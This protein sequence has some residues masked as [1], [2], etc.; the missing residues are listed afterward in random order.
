LKL[1]VFNWQDRLNPQAGGAEVHLHEIFSRLVDAGHEVTLVV[2]G[3]SGAP[4]E[5]VVDGMDVHRVGSRHSFPLLAP[6]YYRRVLAR[7]GYDLLIEDLNKVPLWSPVWSK[8]PVVLVVHHLFGGTAFS[9]AALPVA[10]VTWLSERPLPRVYRGCPVQVV[11]ESTAADLVE[12]GFA[13]ELIRVVHNGVDLDYYRPDPAVPRTPDPS[14]VFVGRLQKYKRVDLLIEAV[15]RI[16]DQV[17]RVRLWLAGRGPEEE[18]L[19]RLAEAR[20]VMGHVD[21]LGFVD[22]QRKRELLRTAWLHVITS[23]KEGWGLTVLEAAACAT[24]SLGSDSPGLRDS[25]VHGQTGVLV[26]HG[27]VEALASEMAML[28]TR[29]DRLG[30]LGQAAL[31]RARFFS[32]ERSASAAEAHLSECLR[33]ARERRG[34][35]RRWP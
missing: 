5:A 22:E 21:F 15:A 20:G 19:R 9:T 3:W 27:D 4:R 17:P 35:R 24:P 8:A 10:A 12:R 14:L 30:A 32:W 7:G 34:L 31:D 28:L 23:P 29:P 18:A 26:P 2:S 13:A 33:E 6:G 25:I 1:L 11:S 16:V